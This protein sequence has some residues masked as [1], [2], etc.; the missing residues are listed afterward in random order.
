MGGL[1]CKDRIGKTKAHDEEVTEVKY[2]NNKAE[3]MDRQHNTGLLCSIYYGVS[4]TLSYG[5]TKLITCSL[6][7]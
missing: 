6:S 5:L 2:K 1:T 3:S 4:L 7:S